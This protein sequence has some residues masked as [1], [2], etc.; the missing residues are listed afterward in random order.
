MQATYS[1]VDHLHELLAYGGDEFIEHVESA[2]GS[3]DEE[4]D[5]IVASSEEELSNLREIDAILI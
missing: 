3:V 1:K 4:A 2:E 5:A